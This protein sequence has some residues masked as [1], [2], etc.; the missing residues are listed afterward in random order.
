MVK[1]PPLK[2]ICAEELGLDAISGKRLRTDAK[3]FRKAWYADHRESGPLISNKELATRYFTDGYE[4]AGVKPGSLLWQ[5]SGADTDAP[6]NI[7]PR[8][9]EMYASVLWRSDTPSKAIQSTARRR[10]S[11]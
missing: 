10:K 7:L 8:N 4:V 5:P 6:R 9:E 3:E 1:L 2:D 11:V